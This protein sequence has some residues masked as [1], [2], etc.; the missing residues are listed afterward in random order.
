MNRSKSRRLVGVL[1][2]LMS[3]SILTAS[4]FVYQ[5]A[6][7]TVDQNIVEVA[8]ITLKSSDL[9]NIDEGDTKT[10]TKADVAELGSAISITTTKANVYL[11]LDSDLNS[12]DTYYNTYNIVVKFITVPGLSSHDPG[13]VACTLTPAS[14][15][16]S[17]IDLDVSG[18]WAFDFEITTSPKSVDSNTATTV[19]ITVLAKSTV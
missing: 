4:A 13:D 1:F 8:T 9:G 16:Y 12:L 7:Q 17:S 2:I 19:T 3:L 14:P 6:N 11:H 18:S 10:Y 15:D 5:Q